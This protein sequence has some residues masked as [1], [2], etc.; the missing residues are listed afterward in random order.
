MMLEEGT[1]MTISNSESAFYS[2]LF[3]VEKALGGRE[4]SDRP[5]SNWCLYLSYQ[6]Q[7]RNLIF[8][9]CLCKEEGHHV[10][11]GL[12]GCILSNSD[13]FGFQVII[14]LQPEGNN[15]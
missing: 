6:V 11:H 9:P 1:L 3:L 8:S 12:E 14:L 7:D 2:R 15:F 5:F 4:A 13:P 10:L